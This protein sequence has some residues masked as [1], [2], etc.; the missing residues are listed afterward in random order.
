MFA[1]RA[2]KPQMAGWAA[3]AAARR[4][5]ASGPGAAPALASLSAVPARPAAARDK[6]GRGAGCARR[7][8]DSGG[9]AAPAPVPA[10]ASTPATGGEPALPPVRRTITIFPVSVGSATRD[11]APD[12]RRAASTWRPCGVEIKAGVGQCWN[13]TILDRRKPADVLNQ[14]PDPSMPTSEELAMIQYLPGGASALHAYYVPALS[15]G[16]RGESFIKA[17]TPDLPEAAVVAEDSCAWDTLAHEIG[18]ILLQTADHHSDPDNVMAPGDSRNFNV[19][20]VTAAQCA[21]I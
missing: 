15:H 14:T 13:S 20:K 3:P 19:D 7:A 4:D 11:P 9:T 21:R 8:R 16:D 18:H 2:R 17:Y 1:R 5:P 6:G 12:I 10:P